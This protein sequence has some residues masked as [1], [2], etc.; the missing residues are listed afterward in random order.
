MEKSQPVVWRASAVMSKIFRRTVALL[1]IPCLVLSGLTS[2]FDKLTTLSLSKGSA[3]GSAAAPR[4]PYV[5]ALGQSLFCEQALIPREVVSPLHPLGI[6]L[7]C[8]YVRW[9]RRWIPHL[10]WVAAGDADHQDSTYDYTTWDPR[11]EPPRQGLLLMAHTRR[12]RP[13]VAP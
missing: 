2:W 1:L 10:V 6:W 13:S 5:A 4:K 9:V 11:R 8:L 3:A 12:W 7:R